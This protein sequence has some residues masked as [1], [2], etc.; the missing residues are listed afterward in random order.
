MTHKI[1]RLVTSLIF[2]LAITFAGV[3]PARA[4]GPWY[5]ST[6]GDDNNNCLSPGTPCGTINGAIG[7]ATDGDTINVAKGTYTGTG[8]EVVYLDK[9]ATLAGGWDASFTAQSGMSIL[10]G[11][12]ERRGISSI[13]S[14]V[15]I[16]ADHFTIQHGFASSGGGIGISNFGTLI[17]SNS[18]VANST[19]SNGGGIAFAGSLTLNDSTVRDNIASNGGGGIWNLNGALTLNNSTISGNTTGEGGGGIKDDGFMT[20]LNNSTVSGNTASGN[21]GGINYGSNTLI[22]N[23]SSVGGNTAGGMG[24]G[25]GSDSTGGIVTLQNTILSGNTSGIGPDCSGIIG[26]SGYNLIGNNS[27]CTFTSTTGDLVGTSID[28]INPRWGSLQ[29]NGGSTFTHA[30]QTGSPAIDAGNPAAPGS[31]G[32]ACLATD[33]R[34]IARPQ[35]PCCDIGAFELEATGGVKEVTID[36]KPGSQSNPI[37][38]RGSGKIPVAI[39]STLDFDAPSEVDK[40]TL[41]FGRTGDE[42]SLL[43]CNRKGEDVNGDGLLDLVCHFKTKLTGF[44]IGDTEG[45]LKG[46]TLEGVSIEGRDSVRILK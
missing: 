46:Q 7:K 30:L 2:A 3:T 22:L 5:V 34:G 28:P 33:Q 17:L 11:Q 37:N 27:D 24:G 14:N 26:S 43:S 45:F 36:I 32:N 31:G 25:L 4:V 6:T 21:G 13:T 20:I 19:A 8:F 23:N 29:D 40:A 42:I 1:F 38:P 44:Q 15:T 10:D 16:F 12:G 9:D 35:G 18:I 41:T 39:L